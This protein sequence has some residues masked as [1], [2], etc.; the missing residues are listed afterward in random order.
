MQICCQYFKICVNMIRSFKILTKT[1]INIKPCS[2]TS[3]NVNFWQCLIF[4]FNKKC[5]KT[6]ARSFYWFKEK[7]KDKNVQIVFFSIFLFGFL[8]KN[9]Q[10]IRTF[11]AILSINKNFYVDGIEEKTRFIK[12]P[13]LCYVLV[14]RFLCWNYLNCCLWIFFLFSKGFWKNYRFFRIFLPP[15]YRKSPHPLPLY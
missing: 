4:W 9:I 1:L 6:R 12:L 7:K 11:V 8:F 13:V 15:F 5:D 2:S 3:I 14:I 10:W